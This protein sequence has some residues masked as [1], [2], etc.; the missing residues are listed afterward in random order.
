[1]NIRQLLT[2][3]LLSCLL[4]SCEKA[5]QSVYEEEAYVFGTLVKFT[6][7]GVSDDVAKKAI[8]QVGQ[9]FQNMHNEWNAWK[10]GEL[11]DINAAIANGETFKVSDF[12]LPVIIKSKEFYR[13]SDGLFNPAIGALIEA[14]GFHNDELPTGALPS[15]DLISELVA[16]NPSM[17]DVS[18]DGNILS[19]VNNIVQFD[20]GGFGKGVAL[21]RAEV[22]LAEHGIKNA[23]INAGGDLNTMGTPGDRPWKVG[24]RHPVHWG[25][26]ASVELESGE[27][28]YT[29][30][31]Y[32]RFRESDGIKYA[33]IIDPRDGMP[34]KH[35]V[36][37]S[38]IH[39]NG[40]LADA[41][42]TAL[43]IAGPDEWYK[44]AKKMGIRYVMLID[45]TGTVYI[46]PAMMQRVHFEDIENTK[47]VVSDPLGDANETGI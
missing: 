21:D 3:F 14:W 1:M 22:I 10:K 38:V 35:I 23:V 24:I 8:K 29:S 15:F 46:N 41:A 39:D 45:E 13:Q 30:G 11:T 27:E 36:S 25:A 9:E 43:T 17:D 47:I 31:N 5:A 12:V 42:A 16:K 33:H 7:V 19:S 32:E 4:S 18:V 6:V 2:L 28:L 20:F 37:T 40:A 26:I 34:V 44:I